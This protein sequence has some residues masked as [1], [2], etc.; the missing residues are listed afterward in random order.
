[1]IDVAVIGAGWSGLTAAAELAAAGREVVVFDKA[2]GPGGRSSTRRQ[3]G[4]QF[5]HGA[6]YFT[7][8]DHA[9]RQQVEHWQALGLVAPWEPRLAV[10]GQRPD[11]AGSSPS[12]RWVGV[13][14]MNA[15]LHHLA[16]D[17][18]CQY[19]WHVDR[20]DRDAGWRLHG[21]GGRECR[22]RHLLLTAPPQQSAALLGL[23]HPLSHSILEVPMAATWALML[24][25]ENDFATDFDALF[26]NQGPL[27]WLA[28]ND[29]KPGRQGH[30]WVAHATA[31]WSEK[32]LE[33]EPEVVANALLEAFGELVSI[34][35]GISP[36]LCQAHR[37]RYA[38]SSSPFDQG[39][40]IDAD[41]N[42]VVAGDWC[43]GN[44]IEG[45]WISGRAAAA[46]FLS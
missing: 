12:V 45:A 5:D 43:Q 24:G 11:D 16:G 15:V 36:A 17:L 10:V 31:S 26:V 46:H 8:R 7:A 4:F 38:L 44:R 27:A 1:M 13:P 41:Q 9:F 28:R 6:Q 23:E 34:P 3:S 40:M 29:A 35:A 2:R 14:G 19:R 32:H 20:L 18:N 33:D 25:F 39:P 22:A 30:A 37:W 42:L 21:Q